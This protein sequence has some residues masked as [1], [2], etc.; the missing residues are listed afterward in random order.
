MK[1]ASGLR[2]QAENTEFECVTGK[3]QCCAA[4]LIK[5]HHMHLVSVVEEVTSIEKLSMM[6]V[7][8]TVLARVAP[9]CLRVLVGARLL[10]ASKFFDSESILC[11][12]VGRDRH[13]CW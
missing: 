1:A 8:F 10:G 7:Q 13:S 5:Q 9:L 2:I 6:L 4:L 11:F 12:D 3:V